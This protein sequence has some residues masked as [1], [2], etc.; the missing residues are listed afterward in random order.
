MKKI[1]LSAALVAST[2]SMALAQAGS[3]LVFGNVGYGSTK[4]SSDDKTRNFNIRPG[5]GYQFDRN[6][7]VGLVGGFNTQRIRQNMYRDWS[8]TNTY[9]I[10]GFIR[11]TVPLNKTFAFFSQIEAGYTGSHFGTTAS[12]SR[13]NQ[14]NG[15][16]ASWT[17]AVG[18]NVYKGFALNFSYGGID[19][20]TSKLAGLT[21]I[22]NNPNQSFN[23]TLGSQFNIGVSKNLFCGSHKKYR[24]HGEPV[25]NHGSRKMHNRSAEDMEED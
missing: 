15:F 23:V 20:R 13:F 22:P 12:N 19:Y 9:D 17:P 8:Y 21:P 16:Y 1:L 4:N 18:V 24:K 3:V 7:T 25:M 2:A 6:W 5:V 14:T 10:G 11:H